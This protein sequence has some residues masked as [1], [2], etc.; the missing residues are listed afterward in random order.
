MNN[1]PVDKKQTVRSSNLE[2]LRIVSIILI[3]TMH[4]VGYAASQ[5]TLSAE[6]TIFRHFVGA[7]GNLGVSCFVLLSGYFGVKFS[8]KKFVHIS[9][10]TTVYACICNFCNDQYA[11]TGN[12]IMAVV[13]VPRYYNW[14]IT[15]YLAIML[16]SGYINDFCARLDKGSF[17]RLLMLLFVLL[18]V[19]PMLVSANDVL[20]NK[21]GQCFTYFTF[22]YLIG[23]YIKLYKDVKIPRWLTG[24]VAFAM[25]LVMWLKGIASMKISALSAIPLTSNYSP[26]I[27][28]A[29]VS[30]FFLF[31]SFSV[32]SCIVNYISSSVLAVYLLDQLRPTI[33]RFICVYHHTQD[34]NFAIWV[35][36]EVL[37][38]FC[39]AI[40]IDKIRIHLLYKPEGL[41]TNYLVSFC[42]KISYQINKII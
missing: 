29:S 4:V 21:S 27:L 18:S 17:S 15:C 41:I 1:I 20:L 19:L 38:I 40:I 33:D 39:V 28:I 16:L 35:G 5:C 9:L 36:G 31:K 7:I 8:W 6:N 34:S 26:T 37:T 10:L 30:F 14:Y 42:Q 23:R 24:G 25:V 11:F 12:V 22:V 32:Q 3:I 2:L 13:W